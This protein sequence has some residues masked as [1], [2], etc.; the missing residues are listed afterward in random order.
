MGRWRQRRGYDVN[1]RWEPQLRE[2]RAIA[3]RISRDRPG[4][5]LDWGCGWGQVTELLRQGELE[6][7]VFGYDL[8]KWAPLQVRLERSPQI[9][10]H[11]SRY[12][13]RLPCDDDAFDAVLSL[14]V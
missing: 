7:V 6:V 10:A 2:Y 8:T 14:G 4:R 13:V 3:D 5:I 12:Q 1:L 11:R 9:T